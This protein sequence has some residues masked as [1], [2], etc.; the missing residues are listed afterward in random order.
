MKNCNERET[1]ENNNLEEIKIKIG[2]LKEIIK[3]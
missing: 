2:M 1:W 3:I